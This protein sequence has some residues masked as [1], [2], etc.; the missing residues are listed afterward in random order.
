MAFYTF[1]CPACGLSTEVQASVKQGPGESPLCSR[2]GRRLRRDYRRDSPQLNIVNLKRTN[3]VSYDETDF[4][5]T[6][7]DFASP[8]DPDGEKGLRRWNET[9]IP[10]ETNKNPRYP[11]VK[12]EVF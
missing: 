3:A 1:Y 8:E 9:H 6:A 7:E 4:L 2:D 12:K 5:P 11:K 10:R